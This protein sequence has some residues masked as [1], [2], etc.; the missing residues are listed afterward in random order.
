MFIFCLFIS[1][2]SPIFS[3]NI[4]L[5]NLLINSSTIS[6][7]GFSSGACFATQFHTAFSKSVR[8]QI[9]TTVSEF[10]WTFLDLCCWKF[11]RCPIPL[12]LVLFFAGWFL[13]FVNL[14]FIG[15]PDKFQLPN[16]Y[17]FQYTGWFFS[18]WIRNRGVTELNLGLKRSPKAS[19]CSQERAQITFR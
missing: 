12:F 11:C 6:V 13:I 9:K 2:I 4:I 17:I 1:F 5:D 19:M 14:S 16:T 10:F 15:Y 18:M 7:S 3:Q 8:H